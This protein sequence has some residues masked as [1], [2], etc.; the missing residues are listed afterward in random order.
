[1][2]TYYVPHAVPQLMASS[3]PPA[4]VSKVLQIL[5]TWQWAQLFCFDNLF[6]LLLLA[7]WFSK[8]LVL[9]FKVHIYLLNNFHYNM[10]NTLV[11][12]KYCFLGLRKCLS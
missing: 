12:Y 3:R 7:Q 5:G 1:M 4:L 2:G 6:P 8:D 10:K 11:C 9:D